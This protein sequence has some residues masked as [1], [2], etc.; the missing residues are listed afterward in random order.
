MTEYIQSRRGPLLSTTW[1]QDEPYNLSVPLCQGSRHPLG[2]VAIAVGQIM[3]YHQ[4]PSSYSWS[5]M[6]NQLSSSVTTTTTL[7]DFLYS[8]GLAC[9]IDY[10]ANSSGATINDANHAFKSHFNYKNTTSIINHDAF[11]VY[12]EVMDGYPVYMRGEEFD[13]LGHTVGH[14]WVCDGANN[15]TIRET[16]YLKIISVTD[17]PLHFET[18]GLPYET[19][20]G[21][22]SLHMNWG[23]IYPSDGWYAD[24]TGY[25]SGRCPLTRKDIIHIRPNN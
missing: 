1:H 21:T 6:P 23:W 14:A 19:S 25:Y 22:M 7:S 15:I 24:G 8:V 20:Y 17:Y 9:N 5:S 18:A 13:E 11:Q 12:L 4:W 16:Y 10:Y 2:C 3:K